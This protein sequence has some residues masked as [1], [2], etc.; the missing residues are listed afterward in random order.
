MTFDEQL[1]RAFDALS[2]R[3]HD[4]V[5]RQ[6][7]ATA[8]HGENVS[9]VTALAAGERLLES[10]QSIDRARSLH[11]V[12]DALVG[13]AGREASRV[14]LLLVH[15]DEFRGW[16][17]IGFG[18]PLNG[19]EP[20]TIA[21]G[22]PAGVIAE[23]ARTA[24]SVSGDGASGAPEF[25]PLS[26]GEEC[27]A[28]PLTM[29]GDV[30]AV[31]YA[32]HGESLTWPYTIEVLSRHASRCLEALTAM[33]AARALRERPNTAPVDRWSEDEHASAQRYA[34]LLTSEI[35]LY[36]EGQVVAGR[37]ARD[38]ATRLSSEIARARA[39]YEQRVPAHVRERS[40]YFHAE[41]VRTLADGDESLL[42]L[43]I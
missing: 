14:A 20:V 43:R 10:V 6:V 39:L 4:E 29:A 9:P 21:G 1:K 28:V 37:R 41:L 34:R 3:L 35:K 33:K 27:F 19:A 25:A 24:A 36:H 40:D 31:I 42:E 7:A 30:V 2:E 17:F 23:A 26:A 13:A 8:A 16:R 5:T 22:S 15:A 38:L 11:E 12:L 32:D 18:P